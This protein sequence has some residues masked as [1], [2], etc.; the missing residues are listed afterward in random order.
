MPVE[1]D[2]DGNII[3][4]PVTDV[5]IGKTQ[6]TLSGSAGGG[7]PA[8]KATDVFGQKTEVV[9]ASPQ[10]S[11][12]KTAHADEQ[13]KTGR[14]DSA[15]PGG[16]PKQPASASRTS[17]V[18]GLPAD[19]DSSDGLAQ[20]DDPVVGW[21]VVENGPGRGSALQIGTGMNAVGRGAG[22]RISL[23]FGDNAISSEKHFFVSYDPRSSEFAVHRGDGT[24]LTYLNQQ[25]IYGS[26]SL[27]N[28]AQIEV[29]QTTL[30]FVALCG[31]EFNWGAQD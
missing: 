13:S 5:Q 21:L 4:T 26:E 15:Q 24:N 31:D 3:E 28:M 6:R 11:Y 2:K 20:N 7:E 17:L 12:D 9:G 25:P 1:R 30:R 10:Q 29:G 22:Q 23:N 18:G 16:A 14:R 27:Q 8:T 19:E